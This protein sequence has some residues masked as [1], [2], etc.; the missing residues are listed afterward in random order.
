M[1][2]R[3]TIKGYKDGVFIT[4]Y[5]VGNFFRKHCGARLGEAKKRMDQFAA[6]GRLVMDLEDPVPDWV[7][8][9]DAA[10]LAHTVSDGD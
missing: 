4:A 1:T 5:S 3:L 10:G 2:K 8:E 9:L 7:A 6:Q